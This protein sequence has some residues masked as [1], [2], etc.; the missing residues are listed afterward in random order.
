MKITESCK[1]LECFAVATA[2]A[3]VAW[4]KLIEA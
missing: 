4:K 2:T 1:G 3:A